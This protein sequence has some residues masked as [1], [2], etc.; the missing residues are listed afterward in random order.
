M[1]QCGVWQVVDQSF[2]WS[3][4]GKEPLRGKWV[5]HSKVDS[6]NINVRSRWVAMKFAKYQDES[7]FAATPPLEALRLVLS[8][9]DTRDRRGP[10]AAIGSRTKFGRKSILVVDVSRAF[11]EVPGEG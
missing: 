3:I 5:D 7:L 4:S 9:A 1:E 10:S 2:D 8:W 6:E 11:F